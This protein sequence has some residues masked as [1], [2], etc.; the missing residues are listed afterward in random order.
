MT[1]PSLVGA[2][3]GTHVGVAAV[4]ICTRCGTFLCGDCVE[5]FREETPA[6]ANCMPHLIGSP[7]SL[8]A[9]IS[10]ILSVLGLTGLLGGFIVRGRSGLF[11]WAVGFALGFA[12]IAFGVQELRLIRAGQAGTRGRRWAQWGLGVG[13]LF[14]LGF[15]LLLVSFGFFMFRTYGR[16]G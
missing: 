14:A 5:Y 13:A 9:R 2:S 11:V 12:G 8:R 15:G 10:P 1:A 6:C 3:C 4:E 7:A 16:A